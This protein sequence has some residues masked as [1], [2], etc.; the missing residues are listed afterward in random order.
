[1]PQLMSLTKHGSS[2][3]RLQWLL[4]LEYVQRQ[5]DYT[6]RSKL[7]QSLF[8]LGMIVSKSRIQSLLVSAE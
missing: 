6:S 1:M 8:R 7:P 3:L 5:G 2:D 4:C